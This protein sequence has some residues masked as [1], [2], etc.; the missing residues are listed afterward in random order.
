MSGAG[1]RV[2]SV[3]LGIALGIAPLLLLDLAMQLSRVTEATTAWWAIAAYALIGAVVAAAIVHARRD[4]LI[5]A[6]AAAVLL[7]AVA[8]ALPEPLSALPQLP[9]VG[10]AAASQRPVLVVLVGACIVGAIRG[11]SGA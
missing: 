10:D 4:P 5:P 9:V 3:V 6:V 8:P 2:R 1:A 11:R 7:L